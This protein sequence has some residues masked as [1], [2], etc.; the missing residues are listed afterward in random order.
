M[1][2][3]FRYSG[4]YDYISS[5]NKVWAGLEQIRYENCSKLGGRKPQKD[6]KQFILYNIKVV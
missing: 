5:L 6:A 4:P 3:L 2:N 1:I